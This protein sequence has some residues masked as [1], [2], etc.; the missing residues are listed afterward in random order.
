MS[1]GSVMGRA[2]VMVL[3]AAVLC[4]AVVVTLEHPLLRAKID[5]TRT[6]TY[7]LSD[8]TMS[9]LGSLEGDWSINVIMVEQDADPAVVRQVDEVLRRYE[10]ASKR[11]TVRRI[12]PTDPGSIGDYERLLGQLQSSYK[13]AVHRYEQAINQG[14]VGFESLCDFVD[15]QS[16]LVGAMADALPTDDPQKSVLRDIHSGF[17]QLTDNSTAFLTALSRMRATTAA[18]PIP[19]YEGARSTLAAAD[20]LWAT[21]LDGITRLFERWEDSAAAKGVRDLAARSRKPYSE[22]AQ[23]LQACADLLSQLEP[24]ELSEVGRQLAEG[25]CAVILGPSRAAVVPS[26][27]LF[28]RAAAASQQ[29]VK[30]DRRF[31]GEEVISSAIRSMHLKRMPMVVFMHAEGESLLRRRNDSLDLLAMADA[32]R[33]ARLDV[34]EW[35]IGSGPAPIPMQDQ[36]AVWVVV[37]PIQRSSMELSKTEQTLL[38][39]TRSLVERGQ[40]VLLNVSRSVLPLFRQKD[41][42]ATVAS[43][44]GV[45]IDTGHV[46]FELTRV[47]QGLSQTIP[48]QVARNGDPSTIIGQA[49]S[50]QAVFLPYPTPVVVSDVAAKPVITIAPGQERWLAEDWRQESKPLDAAPEDRVLRAPVTAVAAVDRPAALGGGRHRL[51]VVGSSAWLLTAIAD[52]GES[53]GGGRVALH[54]PGNREL[55]LSS[56]EWL[57]GLDEVVASGAGS[58]EVARLERITTAAR[59]QWGLISIVGLPGCFLIVGCVIWLTRRSA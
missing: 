8:R 34:R 22:M 24:L 10:S 38:R 33:A 35:I 19:D 14:Q 28:P 52:R 43:D 9:L 2:V 16:G 40:P 12:D 45:T 3:G 31:R 48:Y 18:Q 29:G 46:V 13:D 56:V 11:L 27:Q 44:L 42:W 23:R 37:P 55:M 50:G 30:F 21:Q 57:A 25:E 5:A 53:L 7:T 59:W 41:P 39:E 58:G 54:F 15:S 6:R 17:L 4:A 32:L 47:G 20:A 1:F 51:V 49:I 26:W 36:T